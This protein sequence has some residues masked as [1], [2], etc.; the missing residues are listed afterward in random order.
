[1]D[2]SVQ[3]RISGFAGLDDK[4]Q[5][6]ELSEVLGFRFDAAYHV[7]MLLTPAPG[8]DPRM[9]RKI[10]RDPLARALRNVDEAQ[11]GAVAEAVGRW[12]VARG[13]LGERA[14]LPT[15]GEL[16]RWV[17]HCQG[18]AGEH[19]TMN[20]GADAAALGALLGALEAL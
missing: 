18:K 5:E 12:A 6:D 1:M 10:A 20:Y 17:D 7:K 11:H 4:E 14:E 8:E 15:I 16:R 2:D 9:T 3:M 19:P 13:H